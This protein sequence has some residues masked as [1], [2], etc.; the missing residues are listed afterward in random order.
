MKIAAVD[1]GGTKTMI[2]I[3]NTQ[4]K[5]LS[6][7]TFATDTS[8]WELHVQRCCNEL[9]LCLKK[10][11]INISELIGMGINL[12]GMV[13]KK[14]GILV[15]AVFS[16]WHNINVIN[17]FENTTGISNIFI[18]NDVNSCA[19]GELL[20]GYGTTYQNFIWMTVST[21]VGGAV[22]IDGKL[23]DGSKGCAGEIGHVK[24]EYDKPLQCPCGQYGCLEA[25]ASGTAITKYTVQAA[26]DS[27]A[28]AQE[29]SRN[30]LDADAFGCAKLAINCNKTAL[31]IYKKAGVYLGRGIS[32]AVNILN[33]QAIIIGGGVSASLDIL[34]PTIRKTISND[35]ISTIADVDVVRTT[36]G[37]EAALI[38]AAALVAVGTK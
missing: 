33:P 21:G 15:S 36:L 29:L 3:L 6:S 16:G 19:I 17:S 22:V 32:S 2:G 35:V 11:N 28:F 37:Y 23:V 9:N 7:S 34:L 38:G 4:G 5:I 27:S 26:E 31:A 1:I 20:F 12:P 10:V 13:D 8:S 24:V 30:N 14:R 18:D 25:Q